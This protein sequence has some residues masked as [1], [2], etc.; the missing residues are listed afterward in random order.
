MSSAMGL[1]LESPKQSSFEQHGPW[2]LHDTR[3]QQTQRVNLGAALLQAAAIPVLNKCLGEI[4]WAGAGR[5]RSGPA[6]SYEE[7][8]VDLRVS[9]ES[10][11]PDLSPG[12][13][14]TAAKFDELS[15]DPDLAAPEPSVGSMDDAS[16]GED[17][18]TFSIEELLA[19]SR[20]V[21]KR[22]RPDTDVDGFNTAP[23]GCKKRRLRREYI[24][25][26]LSRPF[27]LPATHILN[28]EGAAS[29]DKRFLKLAAVVAAR[30]ISNAGMA[31]SQSPYA[32]QPNASSF[33]RRMAISNSIRDRLH[34]ESSERGQ[35]GTA[36]VAA[37]PA[38]LHPNQGGV[39]VDAH[40]PPAPSIQHPA[41]PPPVLRV[42]A[43]TPLSPKTRVRI[44]ARA[45]PP[46]SPASLRPTEPPG[47][48]RRLSPSPRLRPLRSPE[49]R[50]SRSILDLDD[51]ED[52]DDECVAFPTSEHESRYGDEPV[53]VYTD[54][55]LIFGGEPEESDE[56]GAG[57]HYEDYLD[58]VDGIPWIARC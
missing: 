33:M 16:E 9:G 50:T 11:E 31:L 43:Q 19:P 48:S 55:G 32:P 3:L 8:S 21:L 37:N 49:L 53:D 52:L 42:P 10:P 29:G 5:S 30:R 39:T 58:E 46:G 6:R 28:R 24:T 23:L 38:L 51:E 56:E 35:I 57:E 44:Q 25:S 4:S 18:F 40:S 47:P 17:A 36:I 20:A 22:R 2:H 54:F 26:R 7:A 45:S 13:S 27:S 15:V 41:L 34:K 1:Q 14:P 12:L